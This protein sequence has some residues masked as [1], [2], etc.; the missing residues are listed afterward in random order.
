MSFVLA[1]APS[2]VMV[3]TTHRGAARLVFGTDGSHIDQQIIDS[4][5]VPRCPDTIP[6]WHR[7]HRN[8]AGGV[9]LE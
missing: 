5:A 6:A 3:A 7:A 4:L 9:V 1:E 8:G 2:D